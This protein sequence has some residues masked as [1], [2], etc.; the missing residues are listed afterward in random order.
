MRAYAVTSG[1]SNTSLVNPT[2]LSYVCDAW[3]SKPPTKATR[4]GLESHLLGGD[5][6]A[7]QLPRWTS[8]ELM[9]VCRNARNIMHKNTC[10]WKIDHHLVTLDTSNRE[11]R[12]QGNP[13]TMPSRSTWGQVVMT[14]GSRLVKHSGDVN[15]AAASPRDSDS[16]LNSRPWNKPRRHGLES[17]QRG[18]RSATPFEGLRLGS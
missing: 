6:V 3:A 10:V 4:H 11:P 15:L 16:I 1:S 13:P 7:R 14:L 5:A 8:L 2:I 12:L 17:R 18:S 9:D